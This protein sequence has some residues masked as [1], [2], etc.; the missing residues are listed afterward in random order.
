MK[1][2]NGMLLL[3]S[4]LFEVAFIFTGLYGFIFLAGL[5]LGEFLFN[6]FIIKS[7]KK[8]QPINDS[9]SSQFLVKKEDNEL[10]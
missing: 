1:K 8:Q 10:M 2:K 6:M 3:G 5:L 4:I 9:W 7:E